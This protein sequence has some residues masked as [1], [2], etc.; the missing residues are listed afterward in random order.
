MR[1]AG[2]IALHLLYSPSITLTSLGMGAVTMGATFGVRKDTKLSY[3]LVRLAAAGAWQARDLA[4][5]PPCC[6][7]WVSAFCQL[8]GLQIPYGHYVKTNGGLKPGEALGSYIGA[9]PDHLK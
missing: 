7:L 8:D 1:C 6:G 2:A 9:V 5:E 4:P 3:P